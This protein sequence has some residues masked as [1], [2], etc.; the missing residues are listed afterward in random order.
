[1]TDRDLLVLAAKAAGMRLMRTPDVGGV[2]VLDG[3]EWNPLEDDGDALRLAVSLHIC[4]EFG[5]CADD[6]PIVYCGRSEYRRDWPQMANFPDP[7]KATRRAI[8]RAAA[9]IGRQE[10][11]K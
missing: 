1:M 5:Y 8:V 9:E 2:F 7:Y 11:D 10:R 3:R 4:I 6:A